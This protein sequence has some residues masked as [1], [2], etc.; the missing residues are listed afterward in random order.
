MQQAQASIS[1][2]KVISGNATQG[3][4]AIVMVEKGK[5]TG[6]KN[7]AN[8]ELYN[9]TDGTEVIFEIAAIATSHRTSLSP[10]APARSTENQA[11]AATAT[12]T[13]TI[14]IGVQAY[15]LSTKAPGSKHGEN[16]KRKRQPN[17]ASDTKSRK[18]DSAGNKKKG[19]KSGVDNGNKDK[20]KATDDDADADAKDVGES[21]K[22][23]L[24]ELATSFFSRKSIKQEKDPA[25]NPGDS[26][27]SQA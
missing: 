15:R 19:K 13:A 8:H 3:P 24:Q 4:S 22:R 10:D 1:S 6:D 12:T 14:P 18:K 26:K 11:T 7:K 9:A 21:R 5:L 25:S 2:S 17:P 23:K 20:N 27:S 16:G